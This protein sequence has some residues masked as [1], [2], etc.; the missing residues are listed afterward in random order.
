MA[1][2]AAREKLRTR[3]PEWGAKPRVY[4]RGMDRFDHHFIG[5]SVTAVIGGIEECIEG[6]TVELRRDGRTIAATTT[7]AF[8]DFKFDALP[9]DGGSYEVFIQHATHGSARR[10]ATVARTS[11]YLGPIPLGES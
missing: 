8:G 1:E 10:P 5:G 9:G 6:A 7:D 11:L 3:N 4:Y 2:R